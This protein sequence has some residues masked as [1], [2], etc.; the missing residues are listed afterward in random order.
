MAWCSDDIM[1]ETNNWPIRRI[2]Q[3]FAPTRSLDRNPRVWGCRYRLVVTDRAILYD[4]CP[5]AIQVP[6]YS[7]EPHVSF[8]LHLNG[9]LRQR[10][11]HFYCYSS[12]SHGRLST[13][14]S[15]V[16]IHP[17]FKSREWRGSKTSNY[18]KS[19]A[20]GYSSLNFVQSDLLSLSDATLQKCEPHSEVLWE[21]QALWRVKLWKM[22]GR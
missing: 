3:D 6:R 21:C 22:R 14:M 9:L 1:L 18:P 13:S 19:Q 12:S 7:V 2:L 11:L 20:T 5:E 8:R 16:T 10:S 17:K 4:R 15:R